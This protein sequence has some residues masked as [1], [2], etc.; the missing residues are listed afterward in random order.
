MTSKRYSILGWLAWKI[1]SRVAKRKLTA[2]RSK[3]IALALL[4]AVIAAGL[5][6][7]AN[8]DE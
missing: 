6:L 4:A 7:A 3:L 1:A 5:A 2:N 8:D